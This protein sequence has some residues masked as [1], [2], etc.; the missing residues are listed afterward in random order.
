VPGRPASAAT[1][2]G[3]TSTYSLYCGLWR[4]DNGFVSKIHVKNALIVGPLTVLPV[5]YM[6]DG[7][8]YELQPIQVPTAGTAQINVNDALSSAPPAI[9]PH[10]S[11][12]GSAALYYQYQNAGH[13]LAFTEIINLQGSL[14]FTTP[15]AGLDQGPAGPQTL[16]ALWWRHDPQVGGFVA[17]SNVTSSPIQVSLQ[18]TGSQGT[19]VASTAI[20]LQGHTTQMLDLDMLAWGLPQAENQAGGLRL[21]YNGVKRAIMATGGLVNEGI[22]YSTDIPFWYHD[23]GSTSAPVPVTYASVGLMVGLPQ[24]GMGF[25]ASLRFTPFAV[26]ENTTAQP[27]TVT[28]TLNYMPGGS[29]VTLPLP[30][31][32]LKPQETRTLDLPTMLANLGLGGL[33]GDINLSFS[34]TGHGGDLVIATGSVDQTGNFVFPVPA[35]AIGQSLGRA[36]G[37]WTVANGVDTMYSLW[38]PTNAAQDFVVTLHY[39]D[40]S[41]QYVMPVHLAAQASTMIDIGMLIAMAQPDANGNLIPNYMQE[42]SVVFSNPKGRRQW[43]TLAVCGAFYNPRKATCGEYWI[44]CYGYSDETVSPSSFAVAVDGTVQL[45]DQATYADGSV[46]DFTSSSTWSSNDTAVATVSVSGLVKGV[47]AGSVVITVELPSLVVTTGEI[48]SNG[49]QI[50]CPT[51]NL[52]SGAGGTV[53]DGTPV[54]NSVSPSSW[55]SGYTYSNGTI[56]GKYF[57][58]NPTVSLS[59]QTISFSYTPVSDGQIDFSAAIPATTPSETVTITVTSQGYNGS[60]W[61]PTTQG[62]SPSSSGA[63]SNTAPQPVNFTQAGSQS[64]SGGQLYFLYEWQSNTGNSSD[65]QSCAVGE[66]VT[67]PGYVA[68]QQGVYLWPNPPWPSTSSP[69]PTTGSVTGNNSY[70]PWGSSSGTA[71]CVVDTQNHGAFG[72]TYADASFPA[73]QTWQYTCPGVNSGKPVTLLGPLTIQ[74]SVTNSGTTYTYTITKSGATAS[75]ILGQTCTGN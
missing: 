56:S 24:A 25:P 30:V 67:Y 22:G 59:D 49:A 37:H 62:E 10:L 33:N 43:M 8:Q 31:Q 57:G 65:L 14:I 6:A 50:P 73:Y 55:I 7:T 69:N 28:P 4:V 42:G 23:L 35:E 40:G 54:I 63:A 64:L 29:P 3:T 17:L 41:G 51:A 45:D 58:T 66:F 27:L 26:L 52:G 1:G 46:D 5:L 34:I 72:S 53:G 32:Q 75:C 9:E 12:Y 18:P 61:I 47:S 19:Q 48:C 16:E 68:G 71:P 39:G 13:L 36:I 74:R 21:Q 15:F 2:S 44:D 11:Q 60:G 70:C 20:T 38:N